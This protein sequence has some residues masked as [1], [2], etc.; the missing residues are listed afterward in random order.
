MKILIIEDELKAAEELQRLLLSLDRDIVI[1]GIIDSVE[2]SIR[3]LHDQPHPD[4][5]F[6]DIQLADGMCFEIYK[7]VQVKSPIIFCTSFDEYMMEAFDTNAISY[8]LKPIT[9]EKVEAA[10]QK[11]QQLKAVFEPVQAAKA[12]DAFAHQLKYP[13]KTALLVDLREKIIPLQVKD[14]AFFYLDKTIVRI[15]TTHHHQYVITSSLDD[16]ERMVDPSM[17]Y[18]ANRQFLINKGAVDNAE[19]F[20]SRKLVVKLTVETPETIIVSKAKASE[21]LRWLEGV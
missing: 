5:I 16:I 10:L 11:F 1:A 13:Y 2:E 6:S 17:F 9:V 15:T 12:I 3:Y 21:F 4:L 20:F 19:R 8:L 14:I 18:R 7:T